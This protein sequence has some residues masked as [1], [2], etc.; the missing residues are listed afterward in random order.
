MHF[1]ESTGRPESQNNVRE[2]GAM[3]VEWEPS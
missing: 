1:T 3:G 2:Q